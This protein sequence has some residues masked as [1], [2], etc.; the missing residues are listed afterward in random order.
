M[1]IFSFISISITYYF[2]IFNNYFLF[3]LFFFVQIYLYFIDVLLIFQ[4]FGLGF[5]VGEKKNLFSNILS[6]FFFIVFILFYRISILKN[7]NKTKNKVNRIIIIIKCKRINFLVSNDYIFCNTT[8]TTTIT[9]FYFHTFSISAK[10]K[11]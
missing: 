11:Q 6:S 9:S 5:V 7:K 4:H 10:K 3:F 1:I 2:I 8:T